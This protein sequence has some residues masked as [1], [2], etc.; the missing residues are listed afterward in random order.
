MDEL[1]NQLNRRSRFLKS[2]DTPEGIIVYWMSRDQR[3]ED[4][5]AFLY[6]YSKAVELNQPICVVFNLYNS[7]NKANKRH[8]DFMIDG[9]KKIEIELK[10][11][12]VP[13]MILSGNPTFT[14][15][16]FLKSFNCKLLVSDFSPLRNVQKYKLNINSKINISHVE[17]DTHNIIPVWETSDKKEYGAYTIRP[18][19]HRLLSK[20]LV[21][22][23][24]IVKIESKT[25][26][27]FNRSLN[28]NFQWNY[29][30]NKIRIPEFK[31]IKQ[32]TEF[33]SGKEYA[34]ETLDNF[35]KF[36]LENY[37]AQKNNPNS[38][39][40]SGLS[41]YLHFGQI[42]AQ[43]IAL[44]VGKFREIYPESVNSF[45]EELI[46]RKEL[47]DNY[48]YYEKNYD[49]PEGLPQWAKDTLNNHR[50]DKREY[51]YPLEVFE[52]GET[53]DR[54]WNASQL[55]MV[56]TGKMHGYMRMYWAKKILEWTKSPEEAFEIGIYL[57]DKY[58]LD[59][60]DPNGYTG[61]SWALGGLH[62]RPWPE[63]PVFGKVRYMNY[64]GC[65]RKFDV[66]SYIDRIYR[67]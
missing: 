29:I 41:V 46:V 27:D 33:K 22:I 49:N 56:K 53:H 10:S 47:S 50:H 23:P 6:A 20:F 60:R 40:L 63:R 61:I 45:L 42:S 19:I 17:V 32:M 9:L 21:E 52:F 2:V 34:L 35:I 64:N 16:E 38:S 58:E 54:L 3:I 57:N 11:Y 39:S 44:E 5:Y 67:I 28:T 18:K 8:L 15:P 25:Q 31:V 65:M 1:K 59:G 12:N 36:R 24:A 14:I 37:S 13:F 26:I 55:E 43:R 7:F 51:L 4:N 48:C 30:I 66:E 62:D